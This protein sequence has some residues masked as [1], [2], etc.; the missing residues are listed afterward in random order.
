MQTRRRR[1]ILRE[2]GSS[3]IDEV[4]R[5]RIKRELIPSFGSIFSRKTANGSALKQGVLP[6]EIRSR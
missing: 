6:D 5:F 2:V 4:H 1:S 3:G